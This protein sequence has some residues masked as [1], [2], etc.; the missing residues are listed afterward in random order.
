LCCSEPWG[1]IVLVGGLCAVAL[2]HCGHVTSLF[3]SQQL[4]SVLRALSIHSQGHPA[5]AIAQAR[6]AGLTKY[7][8][9][10]G[11]KVL[12]RPCQSPLHTQTEHH[13]CVLIVHAGYLVSSHPVVMLLPLFKQ[14]LLPEA[15]KCMI[16]DGHEDYNSTFI[17][18]HPVAC[19]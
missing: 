19:F 8:L 10:T 15:S 5:G 3:H 6:W 1:L 13:L 2:F 14:V 12:L 4:H 9:R 16:C 11:S 17:C 18:V 7:T